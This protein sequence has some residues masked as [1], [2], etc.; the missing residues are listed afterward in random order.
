VANHAF[1]AQRHM[2]GMEHAAKI[3]AMSLWLVGS[4]CLNKNAWMRKP[5]TIEEHQQSRMIVD[6]LHLLDCCLESDG[7]G[8]ILV[9]S[10]ERARDF[11]KPLVA[12]LVY[13]HKLTSREC[14]I[15]PKPIKTF[16]GDAFK[17]NLIA[18]FSRRLLRVHSIRLNGRFKSSDSFPKG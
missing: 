15:L 16:W 12:I 17:I 6:P 7:G 10:K 18:E 13:C 2:Y 4:A 1:A 14:S 9:T 8:A 5:L 11:P 3:W